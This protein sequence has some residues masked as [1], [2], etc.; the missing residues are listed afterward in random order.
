LVASESFWAS[1]LRWRLRGAWMWPAFAALTL[2]DAVLLHEL[3]PIS[4]GVDPVPALLISTFA[5]LF[6]VAALAP[7]LMWLLERRSAGHPDAPPHEVTR[8]RLATGLLCA[9]AV[10]VVAAGLAGQEAVVVETEALEE[11]A[12]EVRAFVRTQAPP[13]VQRN[14]A[15]GASNTARLAEDGYF[16]NCVPYE[17][18]RRQFCFFVDTKTDPP[19]VRKDPSTLNNHDFLRGPSAP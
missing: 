15:A 19:T 12:Q 5:N 10:A 3:P 4:T 6:I 18:R 1:R 14:L 7:W 13:D 8:D 9:G 17:D 11:N 16:R 2:V